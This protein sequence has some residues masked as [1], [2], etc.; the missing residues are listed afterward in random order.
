[1]FEAALIA[2]L[3]LCFWLLGYFAGKDRAK[4]RRI[5]DLRL[6]NWENEKLVKALEGLLQKVVG[7]LE[8]MTSKS[9][10]WK[11]DE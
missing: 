2:V 5:D 11:E 10:D 9:A 7:I 3:C 8:N 6:Q 4:D 1:M